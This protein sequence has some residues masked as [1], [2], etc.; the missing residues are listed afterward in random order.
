MA[1][2]IAALV[3]NQAMRKNPWVLGDLW[4]KGIGIIG[5]DARKS[6][7]G[8]RAAAGG[9][10]AQQGKSEQGGGQGLVFVT[11]FDPKFTAVF[12]K[13]GV[14]FGL[15]QEYSC[16]K[17]FIDKDTGKVTASPDGNIKG[18]KA[19]MDSMVRDAKLSDPQQ[20]HQ[21]GGGGRQGHRGG[22]HRGGAAA[23][24]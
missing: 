21:G 24:N 5:F 20:Q 2:L 13:K 9:G 15:K 14:M 23:E 17:I 6:K 10:G 22:R 12:L 16:G 3:F 18:L 11:H 4:D 19:R 8:N 7:K 1:V